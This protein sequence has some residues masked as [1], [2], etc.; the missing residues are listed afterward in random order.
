MDRFSLDDKVAVDSSIHFRNEEFGRLAVSKKVSTLC[1]NDDA[2]AVLD[3]CDGS[4]SVQEVIDEIV[5]RCDK[6]ISIEVASS[7]KK[8]LNMMLV[9]RIINVC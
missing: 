5:S 9:N 3:L 8:L 6:K 7:V 4:R 2:I 1:F